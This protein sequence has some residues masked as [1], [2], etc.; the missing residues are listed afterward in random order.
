MNALDLFSGIGGLATALSPWVTTQAYCEKDPYAQAVLMSRIRAGDIDCAPIWDDI[1]TLTA[2]DLGTIDIIVGGFPCQDISS[3]GRGAGLGGKRSGLF[4]E[5]IRLVE[6]INPPF[7]FLENVPAIRTRGLSQVVSE[8]ARLRYDCRWTC[9]SASDVGA[10]HIRKRW[11]FLAHSRGHREWDQYWRRPGSSRK[12]TPFTWDH[13][14]QSFVANAQSGGLEPVWHASHDEVQRAD[15]PQDSHHRSS[16]NSLADTNGSRQQDGQPGQSGQ[17]RNESGWEQSQR[18]S[19][20]REPEHWWATE[21]AIRR[22]VDGTPFRVDRLR[23]LGNG[24]VPQQAQR[25]FQ[26]LIGQGS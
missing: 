1:T 8:F 18:Y 6:E 12:D 10:P 24:V 19:S 26:K 5:V 16:E 3:A 11:F 21:P 20:E 22:V 2:R 9:V 25:A 23:C 17:I 14:S 4:Y 7:V 15:G 13:G